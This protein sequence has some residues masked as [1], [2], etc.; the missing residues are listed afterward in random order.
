MVVVKEKYE[1]SKTCRIEKEAEMSACSSEVKQLSA[2]KAKC[3]KIFDQVSIEITKMS[4]KL[5]SWAKR[6]KDA[7]TSLQILEKENPWI[8][9]EKS[10]FGLKDSDFDFESR[11]VN[12]SKLRLKKLA[13]EQVSQ[14]GNTSLHSSLPSS[15]PQSTLIYTPLHLLHISRLL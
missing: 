12:E 5:A 8:L 1:E 15:C 13:E 3:D 4:G 7:K 10:F 14:S 6:G 9:S 2:V 11:D